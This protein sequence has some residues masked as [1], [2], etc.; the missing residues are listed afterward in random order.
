VDDLIVGGFFHP[1]VERF[2]M[3][4]FES[5]DRLDGQLQ[6]FVGRARRGLVAK[7]GTWHVPL[8]A[9]KSLI[10]ARSCMCTQPR[11]RRI[12]DL[13]VDYAITLISGGK[14]RNYEIVMWDRPGDSDFTIRVTWDAGLSRQRMTERVTQRLASRL[15]ALRSSDRSRFDE[16]RPLPSD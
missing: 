9:R 3:R 4:D 2:E 13:N 11:S 7:P 8:Q 16:R 6:R 14:S 5:P 1:V 12:C 10:N 15:A